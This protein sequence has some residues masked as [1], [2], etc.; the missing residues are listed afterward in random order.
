MTHREHKKK[1]ER[2]WSAYLTI[3]LIIVL[4]FGGWWGA[5][6]V[7]DTERPVTIVNGNSMFP[8]L[9]DGDVV[10][11]KGIPV[12]QLAEDFKNGNPH[13]IVFYTTSPPS[14]KI[15]FLPAGKPI[16]HRI[17]EITT[18]SEGK[19]GFITKGDNNSVADS[20]VRTA[21]RIVGAVIAGPYPYIGAILLFLQSSWGLSLLVGAIIF[22]LIWNIYSAL[23]KTEQNKT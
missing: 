17:Y 20:G 10:I 12:E 4:Y 14:H 7:L 11:L 6:Y 2:G 8:A 15:L 18:D 21:D 1:K 9:K 16:I 3:A 13:I 19:L 23:N 5:S 22:L